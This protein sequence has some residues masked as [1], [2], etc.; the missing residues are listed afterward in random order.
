MRALAAALAAAA[1]VLQAAAAAPPPR[2][3]VTIPTPAPTA[4]D[5]TRVQVTA[6]EFY[7]VLSRRVVPPGPAIVQ[8]VNFGQDAHDLRM[9]R[10]GGGRVYGTPVIQPGHL[11]NLKIDLESGTYELWCSVAN[12]RALG[13]QARLVV[14]PAR[15]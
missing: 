13:M 2:P 3:V 5:P 15:R 11:F 7:Y 1:L 8:L 9:Q 4:A 6:M 14:R 10:L 12:H